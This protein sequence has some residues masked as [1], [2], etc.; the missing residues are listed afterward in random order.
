M[1]NYTMYIFLIFFIKIIYV[2]LTSTHVYLKMKGKTGTEFDKQIMYWKERFEFVF[3]VLMSFLLIY[4]FNPRY[5]RLFMIN[6][7]TKYLLFLFGFILI[8][9]AKWNIFVQ[10]SN[11]FRKIQFII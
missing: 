9:T 10:E 1:D 6:H 8:I 2:I 7:E 5:N 11:I 3:I 4:L